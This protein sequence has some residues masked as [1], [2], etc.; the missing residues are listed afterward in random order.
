M[1]CAVC[2]AWTDNGLTEAVTEVTVAAAGVMVIVAVPVIVVY[3]GTV[4]A[5]TMVTVVVWAI[6]AREVNTPVVAL[7]VP[8]FTPAGLTDPIDHVTAWLGLF[9]PTTVAVKEML[10]PAWMVSLAG[11][12]VTEVTVGAA[13]VTV[14]VTE[15]VALPPGPVHVMV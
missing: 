2:P 15:A 8:T 7:I 9:C 3:S 6:V 4:D 14:T 11:L 12:G 5:A 13:A 1:H 10:F